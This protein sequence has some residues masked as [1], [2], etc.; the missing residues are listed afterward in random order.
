MNNNKIYKKLYIF[1]IFILFINITWAQVKYS[2]KSKRAIKRYEKALNAFYLRDFKTARSELFSSLNADK[3]FIEAHLLFADIYHTNRE[4]TKEI[5]SYYKVIEINPNHYKNTYYLLANAELSIGKYHDA[6][7]HYT[8]FLEYPKLNKIY[9]KEVNKKLKNCNFAIEALKSKVPFNPQNMGK[10][11]NSK[12]NDYWPSLTIDEQTLYMTVRI[13]LN[14]NIKRMQEDFYVSKKK[15][16]MWTKSVN[17]GAPMNTANNEGAQSISPD[18][19]LLIFTACNRKDG[20]GSCDLYYSRKIGN[21][22]TKPRNIGP[23]INSSAWE[24]QPS[25]SSDGK[26]LYFVSNRK[27][28]KGNKDIWKSTL[29]LKG[30]WSVPVNLGDSINTKGN[31]TSPFIHPDNET[32]Y[33]SSDG[34]LG[35]GKTDLFISRKKNKYWTKPLNLGYPINTYKEELAMIV[36]ARGELGIYASNRKDAMGIDLYTFKLYDKIRPKPV[37]YV[38]GIVYDKETKKKL[39]SKIELIDIDKDKIIVKS[40]SNKKTGEFITCLLKNKNYAL[41]VSKTG[42]LFY[43]ENFSLK[44]IKNSSKPFILNVPLQAIKIGSRVIL[45]NIFFETDSYIL[46]QKSEAELK[47][48]IRFLFL[49]RKIKIEIGG[50]TD[51]VGS[52][53]YNIKLSNNRARAVIQYLIKHKIPK[54]RLSYKGY[55]YSLPIANNKTEKGRSL[56]RRTEFK[57]TAFK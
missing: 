36:N 29:S 3:N 46:K 24:S 14:G 13:P 27:K 21:A 8:K 17:I 57:I 31:E 11:V 34:W 6:K 22:W 42:Y 50:H 4:I 12:Y 15:N 52:K 44:N 37:T 40:Y 51:N 20:Y 7:I 56:N 39:V 53:E 30:V 41:N 28:G 43:S 45:K 32:F 26:T 5:E 23:P 48:L 55:G 47:K 54:E 1:I 16:G 35:M 33:F 38:K 2:T 10:K 25:I 9:I 18:G 19:Q 49:N